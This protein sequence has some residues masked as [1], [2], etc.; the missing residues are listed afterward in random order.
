M[1]D[2]LANS[3]KDFEA[4]LNA[5]IKAANALDLCHCWQAAEKNPKA[6]IIPMVTVKVVHPVSILGSVAIDIDTT[7]NT[8][9]KVNITDWIY[10]IKG[11]YYG[12]G[13]CEHQKKDG[14][15]KCNV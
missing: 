13:L 2:T 7:I 4:N 5:C 12:C 15:H 14:G 11:Q 10:F 1:K 9:K 8:V 3:D 6:S